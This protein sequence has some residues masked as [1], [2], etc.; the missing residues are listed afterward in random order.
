MPEREDEDIPNQEELPHIEPAPD[1]SRP[2]VS[3]EEE[4]ERIEELETQVGELT[5]L[6]EVL[7]ANPDH[8]EKPKKKYVDPSEHSVY[9]PS[10]FDRL[11]FNT[12]KMLGVNEDESIESRLGSVW[13][14]RGAVVL[15]MTVLVLGIRDQNMEPQVKIITGYVIALATIGYGLFKFRATDAFSQAVYGAG[16]ATAYFTTYAAILL[17]NTLVFESL[18]YGS[19][20]LFAALAIT[21]VLAYIRGSETAASISLFLIYYTVILSL[22]EG[23]TT[24]QL[25]YALVTTIAVA[26]MAIIFHVRFQW[27]VFSWTAFVAIYGTYVY[28]FRWNV[29]A[30]QGSETV[31]NQYTV[32]LLTILFVSFSI[33]CISGG[34][35]DRPF[36]PSILP[37]AL[38]N[39]VLYFTL[40]LPSATLLWPQNLWAFHFILAGICLLFVMLSLAVGTHSNPL[41]QLY[42]AFTATLI[43]FALERLFPAQP[44]LLIPLVGLEGVLLAFCY[45]ATRFVLFKVGGMTLL[46]LVLVKSILSINDQSVLQIG[47]WAVGS[48][49]AACVLAALA[50]CIIAWFYEHFAWKLPPEQRKS[51]GQWFLADS[52]FDISSGVF[53]ILH[54]SVAAIIMLALTIL[55]MGENQALPFILALEGVAFALTGFF[56]LTP[57]VEMACVM[58]LMGSHIV[59]HFFLFSNPESFP[60]QPQFVEYTFGVVLITYV[61]SILWE[62][63]LN[64]V[65]GGTQLE[66]DL[67]ASIPYIAGSMMLI[68]LAERM[69]V[70]IQTGFSHAAL[71]ALMMGCAVATRM[72]GFLI[73]SISAFALA[74]S[75]FYLTVWSLESEDSLWWL[76]GFLLCHVLGERCCAML[77]PANRW[78]GNALSFIR[79]LLIIGM[80]ASGVWGLSNIVPVSQLSLY[81]LGLGI[82][83]LL[84][85]VIFR[86]KRYRYLALLIIFSIFLRLY[87]YDLSNLPQLLKLGI[88]IA[89]TVA[90]IVIAWGYSQMK[91]RTKDVPNS[92]EDSEAPG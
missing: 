27:A 84:L 36:H 11:R 22:S 73:A 75:S 47:D 8:E 23:S 45:R 25:I 2:K 87:L 3:Q 81:W 57:Q 63:F 88:T 74:H 12:R 30:W 54:A 50:L 82:S 90:A 29:P 62:R 58:L 42:S 77:A 15:F 40:V 86:E 69:L 52:W 35:K 85:G 46:M 4:L 65:E 9:R 34:R 80:V 1:K 21:G 24:E 92:H 43:P 26:I 71:A 55:T 48:N 72:N 78:Y 41:V 59:Y 39:G 89:V 28:F 17:P 60:N 67:V 79:T 18:E 14:S 68:T 31:F 64:R 83:T 7:L 44:E 76:A 16:L 19:A 13:L 32:S 37:L 66:H 53:A 38:S 6:I 49:W 33:A 10:L 20:I 56:L 70:G 51:A 61:G 91:T 5:S